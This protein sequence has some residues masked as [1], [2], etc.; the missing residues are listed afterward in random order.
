MMYNYFDQ[1][2]ARLKVLSG[3]LANGLLFPFLTSA[4]LTVSQDVNMPTMD[5]LVATKHIRTIEAASTTQSTSSREP[6]SSCSSDS[7][8]EA[9]GW[10]Q[11]SRRVPIVGVSACSSVD[12]LKSKA[13]DGLQLDPATGVTRY[14]CPTLSLV[15]APDRAPAHG[16]QFD[17]QSCLT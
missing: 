2:R 1:E 14:H 9:V 5:G 12:Q 13:L 16:W 7:T 3:H 17:I 4:W 8:T 11:P 15:S 10:Q 6:S